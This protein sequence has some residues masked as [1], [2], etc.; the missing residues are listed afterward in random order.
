MDILLASGNAH[1]LSEMSALFPRHRLLTPPDFGVLGFSPIEDAP[2]FHGNALIK[3]RALHAAV[4]Q[5]QGTGTA[6]P[7]IL[8]DDSG[9]CVDAL[10]GG[11]GILSARYG[12][13][14]EQAPRNDAERT[15]LL[16]RDLASVTDPGAR[17]AHYVCAIVLLWSPERFS[18]CQETWEGQI[19]V[20]PSTGSGGFGYDPVFFL[21]DEGLTV[22]ELSAEQK[23]KLSHRGKAAARIAPMLEL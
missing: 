17:S 11:P 7:P 13:E 21:P 8:A 20:A 9:I 23:N 1:K 14:R 3:A 12:A 2:D 16:L 5:L 4:L 22:S 6:V 10:G 15:A 19:S 18:L